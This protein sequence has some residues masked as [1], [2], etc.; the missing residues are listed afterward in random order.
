MIE[1]LFYNQFSAALLTGA[2]GPNRFNVGF[3]GKIGLDLLKLSSSHLDPDRT[4]D[5]FGRVPK[6]R[7]RSA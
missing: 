6:N 3:E 1:D 7:L 4:C 5:R 2:S